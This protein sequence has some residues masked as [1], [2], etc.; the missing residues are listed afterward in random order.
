MPD[1]SVKVFSSTNTSA[2]TLNNTAG[3]LIT[4]L[5]ACL[6]NGYGSVTLSSLVVSSNVAT[7][8]VAAGH[9][10][11]MLG[12]VGPV[13]KIEGAAPS[14]LNGE[15]RITVTTSTAFTFATT[16]IS[17][18]T[19]TGTIT[20]KRAPAGFAK[21]FS[22]TNKAAYR[23]NDIAGTRFFLRIDDT[24]TTDARVRGYEAMDDVDTVTSGYGIFPT[25][26]Q[27]SGGG[28]VW[29]SSSATNQL[30][31]LFSDGQI[32]YFFDNA[33]STN[34]QGGFCFGDPD[35]Y[36]ST[37][38]HR[39]MILCGTSAS[40][41]YTFYQFNTT[42]YSFFARS[43]TQLGTAVG[44]SRYSHGKT[45]ALCSGGQSYPAPI[46]DLLHLWPVECWEE[47]TVARGMMPG[48]WNPIHSNSAISHGTVIDSIPQLPGRTFFIQAVGSVYRAAFDITGPWR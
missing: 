44:S 48:V 15:W 9:G 2:P 22:G 42:G 33:S 39:C 45:S 8:T 6:V 5:D 1:T 40:S 17:D 11:T 27:V 37:D 23:S 18:Q 32:I 10:F 30:W 28:Y 19:A 14:G 16:G 34:W 26:A 35:P 31:T 4:L 25:N 46:G 21:A 47:S 24:G 12:T 7:A 38:A 36:L 13:I 20:A 41:T 29:K 43:Y 3:S